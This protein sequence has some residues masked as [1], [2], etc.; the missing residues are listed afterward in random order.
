MNR[1][2]GEERIPRRTVARLK[3]VSNDLLLAVIDTKRR[4]FHSATPNDCEYNFSRV[5][6][7]ILNLAKIAF[8]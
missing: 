7:V 4:A 3:P 6:P 1:K 2:P 5:V 8:K